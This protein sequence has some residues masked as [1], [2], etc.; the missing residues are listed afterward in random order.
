MLIE[1]VA[2][3]DTSV[4]TETDP[5]EQH[6]IAVAAMLSDLDDAYNA[7]VRERADKAADEAYSAIDRVRRLHRQN[8]HNRC[9]G[10]A[11]AYPCATVVALDNVR[12][13]QAYEARR[14]NDEYVARDFRPLS[15][16]EE[17]RLAVAKMLTDLDD[18]YDKAVR[19]RAGV[20][21]PADIEA[22]NNL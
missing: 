8:R 22:L 3:A 4:M 18:A 12:P 5:I 20:L 2:L 17:H 19:D 10:C 6:Q 1:T 13:Q 9:T 14:G 15:P 16:A 21:T 11:N 7:A